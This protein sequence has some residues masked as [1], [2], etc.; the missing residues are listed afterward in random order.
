MSFRRKKRG[1]RVLADGRSA[2][3]QYAPL[4]YPMVRSD[5]WRSLSGAAVKVWVELRCRFNGSNNGRL[6]LSMD[7]AA[8]LLGLGKATVHRA[9]SE[10]VDRGFIRIT[11]PGQW[12]GRLATEY[13]VTCLPCD[14]HP[15]TN[16]W[17]GWRRPDE[18]KSA[19]VPRWNHKTEVGSVAES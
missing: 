6:T 3:D 15:P 7:E 9:L 8:H 16:E 5:A 17:K 12:Y 1:R 10:L 18:K 4:P 19:S 11:R 2:S 14:G 13:R